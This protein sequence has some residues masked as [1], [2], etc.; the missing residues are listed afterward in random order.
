MSKHGPRDPELSAQIVTAYL[1]GATSQEVGK[2]F[3]LSY[4]TVL[5]M[6]R[7]AGFNTV[8]RWGRRKPNED[9]FI[10]RWEVRGGIQYP[11]TPEE[12]MARYAAADR[13]EQ[14]V[15][16]EP[17][18]EVSQLLLDALADKKAAPRLSRSDLAK[19]GAA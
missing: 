14:A 4:T 9:A 10:G 17:E 7:D 11:V 3:G 12:D 8:P 19:R 5:R 1:G 15:D 6:V 13:A 18:R 16:D 2:E